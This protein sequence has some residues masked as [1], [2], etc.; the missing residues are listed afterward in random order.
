VFTGQDTS[1]G[2]RKS[3]FISSPVVHFSPSTK[4]SFEKCYKSAVGRDRLGAVCYSVSPPVPPSAAAGAPTS[5]DL[6][7]PFAFS[8]ANVS[9]PAG[10]IQST[11]QK[12]DHLIMIH[13]PSA[14]LYNPSPSFSNP[15]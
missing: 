7:Y 2:Q 11:K 5:A 13:Q 1:A 8:S 14:L 4:I 15:N 6:L 12:E 10:T 9:P 3:K